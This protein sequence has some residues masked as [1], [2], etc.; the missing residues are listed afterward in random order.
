[1]ATY[2]LLSPQKKEGGARRAP[3]G[4][5]SQVWSL[6]NELQS[7]CYAADPATKERVGP[8]EVRIRR[9][10]VPSCGERGCDARRAKDIPVAEGE[11][12]VVED[13]EDVRPHLQVL[14]L[15]EVGALGYGQ[16]SH[17]KASD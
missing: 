15:C 1:M 17:V 4:S 12:R 11:G 2:H 13:V 8:Q 7:Q 9:Q 6:E 16:A 5:G 14:P 10:R 3:P